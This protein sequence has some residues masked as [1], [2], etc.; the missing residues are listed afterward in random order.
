[1]SAGL[2]PL[3][4]DF[5]TAPALGRAALP[6]TGAELLERAQWLAT[7]T[8]L[9]RALRDPARAAF[10]APPLAGAT[11][12]L[13][14]RVPGTSLELDPASA[15]CSLGALLHGAPAPVEPAFAAALAAADYA[16]R[17]APYE[18]REPPT[19]RSLH[20]ALAQARAQ[21]TDVA[22]CASADPWRTPRIVGAYAAA[23]LLGT[24]QT[25]ARAAAVA[26]A[27]D[28][29]PG[30]A[31]DPSDAA[32]T[33]RRACQAA[34]ENAARAL[35]LA[36]AAHI[37]ACAATTTAS[38]IATATTAATATVLGAG[39]TPEVAPYDAALLQ[40]IEAAFRAAV[41]DLFPA[42]YVPGILEAFADDAALRALPVDAVLARLVRN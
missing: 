3:P 26:A 10:A 39:F 2:R 24:D 35:R 8:Q 33:L 31:V 30:A 18:G 23:L 12:P 13:G 36:L 14:A 41:A 27:R 20:R 40:R 11:L 6:V 19:L 29:S 38:V 7:L 22:A 34:G 1:M 32:A 37:E 17:R 9:F 25:I 42:R 15:A 21:A 28:A 5:A 16:A 4:S